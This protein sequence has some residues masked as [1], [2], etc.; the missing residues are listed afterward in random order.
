MRTPY[1]SNFLSRF[2]I[3]LLAGCATWAVGNL[4][5]ALPWAG[6][7][8]PKAAASPRSAPVG[9]TGA[10]RG[11]PERMS[12]L[13]ELAP[14]ANRSALLDFATKRGGVCKHQ[15]RL[16]PHV[17]NLRN[18]P[19]TAVEALR[20]APGV[21]RVTMDGE[22]HAMLTDSTP[23]IRGLESQLTAAG[24]TVNGSGTR[25]CIV[26]T[27]ID[28]NHTMYAARIDAAAGF[29]FVNGDADPEDDHGH[30]SHVAGIALGRTG[31]TFDQG[32]PNTAEP[33]QG[34]APQATL[35]GVKVLAANGSGTFSD[36]IAGID[37]CA[38]PA[39][40][41]GPADV[42]NMSLGGGFF[43]GACDSE[44]VAQAVNAAVAAGVVVVAASGNDANASGLGAPAC[45]SGAIAV[46][47]TYD[48]AYPNPDFPSTTAF[49]F[50]NCSDSFP[51]VDDLT[52]FSNRSIETDVAAPGCLTFSAERNDPSG[53]AFSGKCGTSMASP[54]V[55]GLAALILDANPS[56]SPAAVRQILRDSAI[57]LGPPGFDVGY[58]YGRIDVISAVKLASPCANQADCDDGFFC[59]GVED[60][61][62]SACVSGTPPCP[63]QQCDETGDVCV[64]CTSDLD[65]D[66]GVLCNGIETCGAGLCVAGGDPCGG[67][68]CDA[69]NNRC[70][71]C[72]SDAECD[73]ADPCTG[74]EF[75]NE[76]AQ[77]AVV[78]VD[79]NDNGVEDSCDIGAGTSLDV[80]PVNGVPDECD[81]LVR[82]TITE[83]PTLG[84]D[85]SRAYGL[86]D[87]AQVVG[88]A[89]TGEASPGGSAVTRAYV[90]DSG[91]MTDLGTLGGETSRAQDINNNGVVCGMA[92]PLD[93]PVPPPLY[94]FLKDRPV[95]WTG[96]VVSDL[97][98][99][100]NLAI[101]NGEAVSIN[102]NGDVTGANY[103]GFETVKAVQWD[104]GG[105]P[106]EIPNPFGGYSSNAFAINN[107]GDIVGWMSESFNLFVLRGFLQPA[108]GK[109]IVDLGNLGGTNVIAYDISDDSLVV[110]RSSTITGAF[111][112]FLWQQG[113]GMTD[114][115]SLGGSFAAAR[116][117]NHSA[118]VVGHSLIPTS[119][120]LS[121]SRAFIWESGVMEDLNDLIPGDSGWL[122]L[123]ARDINTSGEIVGIGLN[124]SGAERGFLLTPCGGAGPSCF[125]QPCQNNGECDD[126]LFC[127]GAETCVTQECTS[128]TDPC[129]G[130]S[131][132]ELNDQCVATCDND[133]QCESGED[134]N[135]CP[136]DCFSG[137]GATCGNGLCETGDGE[138][139]VSCPADCNGV[140]GGKPSG[141]FCCGDGDGQN[142]IDCTDSR[143]TSG[144]FSCT[145]VPA[146]G[147]CCGD[148]TC[149]G[150]EDLA[151]CL[152]DCAECTVPADCDDADP[153]TIDDCTGGACSNTPI[154]CDD[155]DACTSDSCAGGVC[156]NNPIS[157]D[158]GDV[159]TTDSCDPVTGCSHGYP[160][161]GPS[162][163]CCGPTCDPASDP[164]CFVCGDPG[165]PCSVNADC[166]SNKCK[167]NGTCR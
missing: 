75:C 73:D 80:A 100:S 61:V 150:S 65:C 29:D 105:P 59:N 2:L 156:A 107:P 4:Q 16:L 74:I 38:D 109:S 13:V 63:D 140:Q 42:I 153:C 69:A 49:Q 131:C 89:D 41:G 23:L 67:R 66:D 68:L 98:T 30:G 129:P 62:G 15:Y 137:S 54:H 122:L 87:A 48:S 84:G 121:D 136:N 83:I 114:L 40:P 22:V 91:T 25:I 94:T 158:D 93:S 37:H 104:A 155:G 57:D 78:L 126:G 151:N 70:A 102:D 88:E 154:D 18:L 56:L 160:P 103:D 106:K 7:V 3:L 32:E 36:V 133:G 17:I 139:C 123:E 92:E 96:G 165:A 148:G 164:D 127:N 128:G 145:S 157:C 1:D 72:L 95:I 111:R 28:S 142:P 53:T 5:A 99:L 10:F 85:F 120:G 125:P 12:V 124:S 118:Q 26:D 86:N 24:L 76:D 44:P 115:G 43:L 166:C 116:G 119:T 79:C 52:C 90:W 11:R 77:C 149:E 101:Y 162:D 163:G 50:S 47:A 64:A 97:G 58:G 161:C 71:D 130:Q 39:L 146:A 81:A 51:G 110:G 27:G 34:V 147:S 132:D 82:F 108:G 159:C 167:G 55:A 138:D 9:A 45:A 46:A 8:A 20:R 19:S 33:L 21:R 152:I 14:G 134:C 60:C 113:S 144:G 135:N 143:C 35:I 112:P 6:A 141:R 117:I 31:I